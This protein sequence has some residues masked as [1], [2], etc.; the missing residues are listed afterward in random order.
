[1]TMPV[2]V[3]TL[4][5]QSLGMEYA[6]RGGG[7]FISTAFSA[8]NRAI[9]IPFVNTETIT[10]VK[11][12]A[13]N[14]ATASGNIDMGIYDEAYAKVVSI[15][16]TAQAGTDVIQEFNIADTEIAPGRY[17]M[18]VAMDNTTGTL[19]QDSGS[20]ETSKSMGIFQMETAF[21]LPSTLTPAD[22]ATARVPLI[23]FSQRTLV[24]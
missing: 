18:V 15:G 1:M 21:A 23:G 12:W 17:Y 19:R 9:A 24:A 5:A 20:T 22:I 10:L 16:S 14:G 6:G 7:S 11:L 3:S 2:M 8:A 4:S 13:Y